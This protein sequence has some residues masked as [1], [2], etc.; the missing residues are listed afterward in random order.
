MRAEILPDSVTAV[1]SVPSI[2]PGAEWALNSMSK[3]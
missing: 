2:E 3:D 1:S